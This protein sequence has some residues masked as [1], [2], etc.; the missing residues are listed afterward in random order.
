VGAGPSRRSKSHT[1]IRPCGFMTGSSTWPTALKWVM[2]GRRCPGLGV[3]CLSSVGESTSENTGPRCANFQLVA[4][5]IPSLTPSESLKKKKKRTS[6]SHTDSA[7]RVHDRVVYLAD[8]F[9]M[10]V[11]GGRCPGLGGVSPVGESTSPGTGPRC[12]NSN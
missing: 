1:L 6:K 10:W 7:M 2:G 4:V 9:K 12:A 5:K 3:W 11:V 8:C